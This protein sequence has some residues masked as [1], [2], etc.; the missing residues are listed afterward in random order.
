[1]KY[2]ISDCDLSLKGLALQ[3]G[4]VTCKM[5]Y[6]SCNFN[7]VGGPVNS[8]TVLAGSREGSKNLCSETACCTLGSESSIPCVFLCDWVTLLRIIFSSSIH[9]PKNCLKLLFLIAG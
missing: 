7:I 3:L 2:P 6:L 4:K 9:L 1:M 8:R 5:V